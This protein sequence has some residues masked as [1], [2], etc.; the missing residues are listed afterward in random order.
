MGSGLMQMTFN[1]PAALGV[2]LIT[3]TIGDL[4]TSE[5][6][7]SH[8]DR[9]VRQS[10]DQPAIPPASMSSTTRWDLSLTVSDTKRSTV[11]IAAR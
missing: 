1:I 9:P 10:T 8:D 3:S 6:R 5:V 2:G 11:V 4:T 7:R